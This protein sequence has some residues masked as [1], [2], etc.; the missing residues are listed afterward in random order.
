MSRYF[1]GE[2]DY[3]PMRTAWQEHWTNGGEG[4]SKLMPE[5]AA[6]AEQAL[7]ECGLTFLYIKDNALYTQDHTRDT[8]AFWRRYEE[9]KQSQR[10]KPNER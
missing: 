4:V 3:R 8:G 6:S 1:Q 7:K 10:S 5:H 2:E 9:L